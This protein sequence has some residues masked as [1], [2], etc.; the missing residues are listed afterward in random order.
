MFNIL[1]PIGLGSNLAPVH[2]RKL[3]SNLV[4]LCPFG[5]GFFPS[6]ECLRVSM[7]SLGVIDKIFG[8]SSS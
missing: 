3:T 6:L 8:C 2:E 7:L 4:I 1:C 5:L